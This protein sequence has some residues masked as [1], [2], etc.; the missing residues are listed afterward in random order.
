MNQKANSIAD[1]AAVLLQQEKGLEKWRVER[2]ERVKRRIERVAKMKG[3]KGR[4][5]V[6]ERLRKVDVVKEMQGVEGVKVAWMD[7]RDAE[8]AES[9]P[10]EVVHDTLG[11]SRYTAAWPSRDVAAEREA[12]A[13]AAAEEEGS[14][15]TVVEK[16]KAEE[17]ASGAGAAVKEGVVAPE[18]KGWKERIFGARGVV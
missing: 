4:E 9:W 17:V 3:V 6:K 7:I 10:E 2:W 18:K 12:A 14:E 8:F 13:K 1:L 5:A 15:E 11:K 16:E